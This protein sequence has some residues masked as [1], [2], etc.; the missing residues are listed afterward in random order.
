[1]TMDEYEPTVPYMRWDSHW[2]AERER[3]AAEVI[4]PSGHYS[5]TTPGG[6]LLVLVVDRR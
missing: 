3:K 4:E 2:T 1:M 5:R 6:N